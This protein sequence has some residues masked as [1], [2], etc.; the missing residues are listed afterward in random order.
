MALL[1]ALESADSTRFLSIT[2]NGLATFLNTGDPERDVLE[3]ERL[4]DA[5]HRKGFRIAARGETRKELYLGNNP[6]P[7][8]A[9]LVKTDVGWNFDEKEGAREVLARRIRANESA[10]L[11]QCRRFREAELAYHSQRQDADQAFAAR[12]RSAPGRHDGLFGS[13]AADEDE[14]PLGPRFAAAAFEEQQPGET[15]HPLFGYYFKILTAQ[16]PYAPHGAANHGTNGRLS[17][18]F[19]LVAWPAHYGVSG[20]RS[21]LINHLGELHQ[22]DLGTDTALTAEGMSVYNPDVSWIKA[23]N[24]DE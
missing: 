23:G 22:K 4:L 19:A 11:E 9:P 5:I 20:I 12:I 15:P 10:V 7:F 14:S 8:P 16:G 24:N 6:E 3:R 2:G 18:G 21:F 13:G 17:N 1:A